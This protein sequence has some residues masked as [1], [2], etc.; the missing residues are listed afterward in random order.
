MKLFTMT[1]SELV[2]LQ[3]IGSIVASVRLEFIIRSGVHVKT[4]RMW[5]Q[6]YNTLSQRGTFAKMIIEYIL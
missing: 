4:C 6:A 5:T 1:S 2:A 3:N